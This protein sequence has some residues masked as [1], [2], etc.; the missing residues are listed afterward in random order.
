MNSGDID[1]T[2]SMIEKIID[3]VVE[4]SE[5][6]E[7]GSVGSEPIAVIVEWTEYQALRSAAG[8]P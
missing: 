4:T 8:R 3:E 6:W 5:P 2:A 1:M 7:I